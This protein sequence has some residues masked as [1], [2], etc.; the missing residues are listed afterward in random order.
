MGWECQFFIIKRGFMGISA[1]S[2]EITTV[3]ET[4]V[5][6][7]YY[8]CS[9]QG[10]RHLSDK[11]QGV[12]QRRLNELVDGIWREIKAL[13]SGG[14]AKE[15]DIA[16]VASKGVEDIV[17]LSGQF[18]VDCFEEQRG[19]SL[20][21]ERKITELS[22]LDDSS[23]KPAATSESV[24]SR[25]MRQG[26]AV[27][28]IAGAIALDAGVN[29]AL[30][31]SLVQQRSAAVERRTD[32]MQKWF[33]ESKRYEAAEERMTALS[34]KKGGKALLRSEGKAAGAIS[35]LEALSESR[36]DFARSL[37]EFEAASGEL[38][39]AGSEMESLLVRTPACAAA[40]VLLPLTLLLG[41]SNAE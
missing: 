16:R 18:H 10:A 39:K 12:F 15:A 4:I 9:R 31:Q 30:K 6:T 40:R 33:D 35:H 3:E 11:E 22:V 41:S 23:P 26:E 27:A 36:V 8:S 19:R 32:A 34:N 2:P 28:P 24:F 7:T 37:T 38:A 29:G 17:R 5:T 21:Q 20:V 1:Y 25:I 13:R 14:G